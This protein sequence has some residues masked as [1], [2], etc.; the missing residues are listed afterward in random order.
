MR[1]QWRNG[2]R[3]PNCRMWSLH[4]SSAY[5]A[6]AHTCMDAWAAATPWAQGHPELGA[7]VTG[8]GGHTNHIINR[9]FMNV[10]WCT[11]R[12]WVQA[13]LTVP[14]IS[15]SRSETGFLK[16]RITLL[17]SQWPFTIQKRGLSTWFWQRLSVGSLRPQETMLCLDKQL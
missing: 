4:W 3:K 17:L 12:S 1:Y 13:L 5:K 16:F 6:H 8:Q 14:T 15:Y 10:C 11:E 7:A 9:G 2:D